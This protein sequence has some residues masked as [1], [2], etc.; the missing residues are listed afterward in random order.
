MSTYRISKVADRRIGAVATTT[1]VI[2]ALAAA[3]LSWHGLTMLGQNA[4]L[5]GLAVLLPLVIDGTMLVGTLHVLHSEHTGM[6]TRFG[7]GL[8]MAGVVLSTWGN[9]AG[10]TTTTIASTIVH[11]V[12]ALA[13]AASVEATMR[14]IRR[15]VH[16]AARATTEVPALVAATVTQTVAAPPAPAPGAA[17]TA[18]PAPA[19]ALPA[20]TATDA[21]AS[22]RPVPVP[23]RRLHA[24]QP[25]PDVTEAVRRMGEWMHGEQEAGR[26]V[27]AG[28][29]H[30]AGLASSESTARRLQAK[31]KEIGVEAFA[32]RT[33]E[34]KAL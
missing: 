29:A 32:L 11:A 20:S 31:V 25:R 28:R 7:W 33:D 3:V 12:P 30:K 6:S 27:S 4:G 22:S 16:E 10:A 5:G 15:R 34:R 8:T 18:K 17:R 1:T 9:I 21:P 19:P 2:V 26:P 13:L 24:V 23:E 14:I